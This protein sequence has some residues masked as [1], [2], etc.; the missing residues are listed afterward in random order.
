M[1][2]RM[3]LV[4]NPNRPAIETAVISFDVI[5]G[6]TVARITVSSGGRVA[7]AYLLPVEARAFARSILS[8]T[9]GAGR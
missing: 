5:D 3:D 1:N 7:E 4:P 6:M 8:W 9:D 2:L